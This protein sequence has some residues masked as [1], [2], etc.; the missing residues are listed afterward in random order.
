MLFYV[1]SIINILNTA[2]KRI[3]KDNNFNNG[4][5]RIGVPTHI[6]V[7]LLS[8]IINKFKGLYPGVRFYIESRSTKD[9][10]LML[11]KR[12][13]DMILDNAP[14]N[15]KIDDMKV[16]TLMQYDNCFAANKKYL[17]LSQEIIDFCDLNKYQLLLPAERTSTR[18]VLE[19][20]VKKENSNL[21]LNPTVEVSTTELM[22]DLV[23]KGLGI[24]YFTKSSVV[25]DIV[26]HDL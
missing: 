9:M 17:K 26:N 21:K 18:N 11:D 12:E 24:G 20:I 22:Y 8:E 3:K 14:L 1:E 16:L 10:M 2:E 7:F 25:N 23:K 4:E 15:G 13:I 5:I 19:N 6:G